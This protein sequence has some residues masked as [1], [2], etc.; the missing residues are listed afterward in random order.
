MTA[1]RLFSRRFVRIDPADRG[2]DVAAF[3]EPRLSN[4]ITHY[5]P[6][7][8]ALLDDEGRVL[9]DFLVWPGGYGFLLDCEACHAEELVDYLQPE[10]A[11][12][13]I[14]VSIDD[15]LAAHYRAHSGDGAASDPRH[16]ALGQRWLQRVSPDD[17]GADE[18]WLACRLSLGVAEGRAEL[19]FGELSWLQCN[20]LE[21]KGL[22]LDKHD[23]R[24][25]ARLIAERMKG[26]PNRLVVIPSADSDPNSVRFV[27]NDLGLSVD[28]RRPVDLPI[29]VI[30]D[31]LKAS[32]ACL[33]ANA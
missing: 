6:V 1:T 20:A 31:W 14:T 10:C 29:G 8:A 12:A 27:H 17:E 18:R 30:P 24:G 16:R 15:N 3:L 28:L 19:G 32:A 21:L 22:A 9:F 11:P 25:R 2:I 26:A 33:P 4:R 23:F 13:G 5:L 7:W